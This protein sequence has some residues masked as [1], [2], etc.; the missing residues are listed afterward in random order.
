MNNTNRS[1][2][3]FSIGLLLTSIATV[4]SSYNNWNQANQ[5]NELR[6]RINIMEVCFP[7]EIP[8]RSWK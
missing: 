7:V 6:S 4:I 1:P 3:I 5:I 2:I 8:G